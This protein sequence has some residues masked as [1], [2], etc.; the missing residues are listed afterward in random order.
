MNI[1][2]IIKVIFGA[3]C[4]ALAHFTP[5][6]P[7][8]VLIFVFVGIDFI[9]GV[10]ASRKRAINRSKEKAVKSGV[11]WSSKMVEWAFSSERARNTV[12]KTVFYVAG[13]YLC[14]SLDEIVLTFVDIYFEKIFAG[15]VL[16]VELFSFLENA[17]DISDHP[18]FR[19]L[20]NF[21]A[22]KLKDSGID[23]DAEI[24]NKPVK[25]E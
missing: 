19:R 20:R 8:I 3:L 25:P 18:V 11:P 4:S 13:V 24:D 10:W 23:I 21:T 1:A 16:G 9:T 7:L 5:I 6:H 12:Y 17:A 15:F 22:K 2:D 14:W